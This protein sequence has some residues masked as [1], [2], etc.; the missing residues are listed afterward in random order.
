MT[1]LRSSAL[2]FAAVAP[3]LATAV[4][5]ETV[6]ATSSTLGTTNL[7]AGPESVSAGGVLVT[8]SAQTADDVMQVDGDGIFINGPGDLINVTFDSDVTVTGYGIGFAADGVGGNVEFYVDG[9]TS[10]FEPGVAAGSYTLATPLEVDTGSVL[11]INGNPNDV[12]QLNALTFVVP[13]PSS[14]A[15][16]ALGGLML[17]CRRR[18]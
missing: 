9:G 5:A 18:A 12:S 7:A 8:F 17:A 15:V 3:V 16:L 10:Y 14:L 1:R 6:I 4:Q 13:E 2:A 11:T